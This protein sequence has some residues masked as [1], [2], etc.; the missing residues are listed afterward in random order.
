MV[1]INT[2]KCYIFHKHWYINA[3]PFR[4]EYELNIIF[5]T[6]FIHG[7]CVVSVNAHA[8]PLFL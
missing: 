7:G 2:S 1:N 3:Y 4:L 6:I 5:K 8:L